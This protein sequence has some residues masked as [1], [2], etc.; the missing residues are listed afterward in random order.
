VLTAGAGPGGLLLL[1]DN[2]EQLVDAGGPEELT[3]LLAATPSAVK[4]L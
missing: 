1:L 4:F 3:A 2:F